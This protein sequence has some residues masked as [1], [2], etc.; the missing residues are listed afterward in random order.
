MLIEFVGNKA[1]M[2]SA[3]HFNGAFSEAQ[4]KQLAAKVI[5]NATH[6]G[7]SDRANA[8]HTPAKII[9]GTFNNTTFAIVADGKDIKKNKVTIVSFYDVNESTTE[10]KAK[11]FGMKKVK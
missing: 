2:A 10:V 5:K 4:M 8:G 11:R 1:Q 3:K 9:W 7:T 6:I